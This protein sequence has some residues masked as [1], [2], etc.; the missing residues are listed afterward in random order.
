M[1][2]FSFKNLRFCICIG[3]AWFFYSI[4]PII[5]SLQ[6]DKYN[7]FYNNKAFLLFRNMILLLLSATLE[8]QNKNTL[9]EIDDFDVIVLGKNFQPEVT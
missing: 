6:Q 8:K 9:P 3:T 4:K 7:Y 5:Q 1:T 2:A